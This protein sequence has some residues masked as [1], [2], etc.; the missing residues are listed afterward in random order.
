MLLFHRLSH[1]PTLLRQE[2]IRERQELARVKATRSW[3]F[4]GPFRAAWNLSRWII[5]DRGK[6]ISS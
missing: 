6:K 5:K 1:T 4:T 3:R 2:L